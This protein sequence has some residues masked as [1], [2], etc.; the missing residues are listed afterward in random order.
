MEYD[1][2]LPRLEA[3]LE[4]ARITVTLARNRGYLWASLRAA[5]AEYPELLSQLPDTAGTV[6]SLPLGLAKVAV[7]NG[8]RVVRQGTYTGKAEVG[9]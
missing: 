1:A 3:E 2:G 9:A 5:L 4:A 6:D 7:L 8:G